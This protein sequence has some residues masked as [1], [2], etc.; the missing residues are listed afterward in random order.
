MGQTL[1]ENFIERKKND[2]PAPLRG[3][4][5]RFSRKKYLATLYALTSDKQ[6]TTAM[7]LGISYG[8]L[9]KWKTEGHFRA[10]V[11][12]HCEEF[13]GDFMKHILQKRDDTIRDL[14]SYSH[15]LLAGLLKRVVGYAQSLEE[16]EAY[17]EAFS[18]LS[19]FLRIAFLSVGEKAMADISRIAGI[20]LFVLA[21]GMRLGAIERVKGILSRPDITDAGRKE[22]IS[23]LGGLEAII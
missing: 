6:I 20:D 23:L 7:E 1:L 19:A 10:V 13:A 12:R 21:K 17:L 2:Y 15:E 14:G 3:L 18:L 5:N 4:G 16:E 11:R 9:R 8:L 22:A